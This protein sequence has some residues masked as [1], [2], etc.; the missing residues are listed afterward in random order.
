MM[1]HSRTISLFTFYVCLLTLLLSST[2]L[3]AHNKTNTL[4]LPLKITSMLPEDHAE[5][6]DSAYTTAAQRHNQKVYDREQTINSLD[7]TESWPPTYTEISHFPR[8]QDIDYIVT[9]SATVLGNRVSVDLVV[10]DLLDATSKHAI[11]GDGDSSTIT[12]TI[13]ELVENI[14]SYT[15]RL[16][17]IAS[18]NIEGNSRID[19]GAILRHIENRSGDEYDPSRIRQDLKDIFKMG[20]FDDVSVD[21][22]GSNEGKVIS[23]IV[24]EKEII[25]S[26]A[27]SGNVNVKEEDIM[28]VL[29]ISNNTI[30]NPNQVNKSESY[31]RQFYKSKGYY[32][33]KVTTRITY[34][35]KDYVAVEYVVQEGV[36]VYIK[37][38]IFQGNKTFDDDELL[39]IMVS[40]EKDWFYWF[41]DSGVLKRD[42]VQ[43]DANRIG[44]FY[45]N[46]GFIDVKVGEP[47]IEKKNEWLYVTFEI[48][49]GQRYKVG[50]I[51]IE[52]DLIQDEY[53][54]LAMSKLGEERYY[55]RDV[56]RKDSLTYTDLYASKGY[57]FADISPDTKK[58]ALNHR[59]DVNYHITKGELVYVNRIRIKGNTRTRDKIIRREMALDETDIYDATAIKKSTSRLKRLDFFEDVSI[60]PEPTDEDDTM[61]ILVDVKE[62]STGT[63]S[64]GAGYSSVDSLMFMAEVSQNNFLG[65]GQHV[66]VMANIGGVNTQ[67]S[68]KFTEPH[69]N[70]SKLSFGFDIFSWEHEYDD[71]TKSSTGVGFR[72]GYPI[73]WGWRSFASFGYENSNLSDIDDLSGYIDGDV[74]PD[75]GYVTTVDPDTGVVTITDPETDEY[76]TLYPTADIILK[77]Q[78]INKTNYVTFGMAKDT[79]NANYNPS[80]G[81]RHVLTIKNAGGPLGGDAQYTKYEGSTSWYFPM[82]KDLVFHYKLAGGF[83]TENETNSLPI[84]ERFYLG[85]LST[86]RGFEN[87]KISHIDDKTGDRYGATN[88]AYQN[89]EVLFP[90]AKDAGLSGVVFFDAGHVWGGLDEPQDYGFEDFDFGELSM[91]AGIGF[92][93]MSPMGPLRLEWG[94]NLDPKNDEDSSVWDFSMG[95]TF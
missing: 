79:R 93:W 27:V 17:K 50:V 47:V 11:F 13:D 23:F 33:T 80:S 2:V 88:M 32:D 76:T 44:S 89:V 37:D 64:V 25:G 29:T 84:Y 19:S 54:L 52:G 34:P 75:T 82:W 77:T 24:K 41:N 94:K 71:Y 12:A 43:E 15:G 39:G 57:A 20:Y 60:T 56:L 55:S 90:I 1:P 35:K 30:Y 87:A 6:I 26:V 92:R 40:S 81:Y 53:Q 86:V 74:D 59:V 49:E 38:I 9:G 7:Y 42:Y 45:Q 78:D 31:I 58:D 68:F 63:F 70:D 62:K 14:T 95:G 16:Y 83:V 69:L 66:A 46:H 91:G 51:T 8:P 48:K 67:Y 28:E 4:F 85:G 10:F 72:F 21:V 5:A 65:R 3:A 61:D 18:V 73:W 22:H 36:K